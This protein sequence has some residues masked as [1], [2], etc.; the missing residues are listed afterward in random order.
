MEIYDDTYEKLTYQ[1]SQSEQQTKKRAL[2]D[3]DAALDMFGE[4]FDEKQAKSDGAGVTR[5][6]DLLH[7]SM[8]DC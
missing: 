2:E 1:I 6:D 3:E 7:W 8:D 4:D 5:V